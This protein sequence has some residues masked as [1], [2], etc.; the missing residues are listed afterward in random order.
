MPY[1]YEVSFDIDPSEMSEL[2]VGHR[3]LRTLSYLRVRLPGRRG[4]I[5]SEALYSVDDPNTTKVIFRSEWSDWDDI[6]EHVGSSLLEDKVFEEFDKEV[7]H[8]RKGM[9]TRVYAKVG[10]GPLRGY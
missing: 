6:Q 2:E 10:S 8:S 7:I 9:L 1:V 3:L 4:F 5:L